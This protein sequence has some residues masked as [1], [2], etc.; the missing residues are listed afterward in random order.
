MMNIGIGIFFIV[1][2]L[3]GAITPRTAVLLDLRRIWY[4]ESEPTDFAIGFTRFM[5]II[6]IILGIF[7]CLNADFFN[8][9]IEIWGHH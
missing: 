9:F 1:W 8:A 3:F 4:K 7:C 2:G 5:G 6:L